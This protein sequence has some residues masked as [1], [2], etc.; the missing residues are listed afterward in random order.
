MPEKKKIFTILLRGNSKAKMYEGDVSTV[1][2]VTENEY[3]PFTK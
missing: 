3:G 1:G 2:T